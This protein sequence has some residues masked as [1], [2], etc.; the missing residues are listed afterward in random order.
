MSVEI[1]FPRPGPL[2]KKSNE[3]V[4]YGALVWNKYIIFKELQA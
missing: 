1:I 3:M 2:M 4:I